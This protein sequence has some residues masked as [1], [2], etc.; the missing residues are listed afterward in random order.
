[1]GRSLG[2]SP[3]FLLACS[4]SWTIGSPAQTLTNAGTKPLL[5]TNGP[6]VLAV[7]A[8][9]AGRTN[10]S[11]D[12]FLPESLNQAIWTNF[13][14]HTNGRTMQMWSVRTHPAGWPAEPPVVVWNTN[15]LMWGM[16]GLTALS[17][18]WEM[19]GPPGQVP[20]TALTRRHGY[21]R[22]HGMGQDGF[23]ERFAGKRVWF[24]T[25]NNIVITRR[26]LRDVVRTMG[27]CGRDYSIMLLDED[28]PP[29][30]EPLSVATAQTVYA[31]YPNA[32]VS[33]WPMF[34]TEQS[35]SV[36]PM[37]AGWNLNIMKGGDSGSPNL[38]PLPGQLVFMSGRTTSGP[39]PEMQADI[40]E[41]CRLGGLSPK[42]YQMQWADLDRFPTY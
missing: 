15:C 42:E 23:N 31:R 38:L 2:L 33:P 30:I 40:D 3:A 11:F 20:I 12:H 27:G 8:V 16:R 29:D 22:G 7:S 13:I 25:T 14:A 6:A 5:V 19:E 4:L 24:V 9:T 34:F 41:L 21:A 28:L 18:C 39:S 26:V 35:G 32:P 1:M 17:P 10:F 37:I 36:C